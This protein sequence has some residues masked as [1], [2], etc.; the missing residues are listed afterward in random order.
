[1]ST[2]KELN[3]VFNQAEELVG[4]YPSAD[5][6][7]N[8]IHAVVTKSIGM[9]DEWARLSSSVIVDNVDYLARNYESLRGIHMHLGRGC[10]QMQCNNPDNSASN[11]WEGNSDPIERVIK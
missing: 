9:D 4:T 11:G 7:R 6:L 3:Q 2:A 10:Y 5:A 8:A 1:M